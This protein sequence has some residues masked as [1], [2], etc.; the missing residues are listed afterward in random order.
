M[1]MKK[2]SDLEI[3]MRKYV[4]EGSKVSCEVLLKQVKTAKNMG[5]NNA[6]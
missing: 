5:K 6:K 1:G 2:R 3:A 4:V